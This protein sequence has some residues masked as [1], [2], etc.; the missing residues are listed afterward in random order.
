MRTADQTIEEKS[1]ADF[2]ADYRPAAAL[3]YI[4]LSEKG[5]VD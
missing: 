5:Q 2:Q 1:D 4:R 3:A